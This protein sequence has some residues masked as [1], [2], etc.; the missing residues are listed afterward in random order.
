[1]VVKGDTFTVIRVIPDSETTDLYMEERR[2][3]T[4]AGSRDHS[5]SARARAHMVRETVICS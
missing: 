2:V 1:M 4:G 5:T 3:D